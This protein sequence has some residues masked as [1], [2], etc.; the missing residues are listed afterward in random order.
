MQTNNK[1]GLLFIISGPSGCGKGTV[2]NELLARNKELKLSISATTRDMR[3]GEQEGVTY[4]YITKEEFEKLIAE[5]QLFEYNCGYSGKYYGTP[6]KYVF[7]NLDAGKDVILEIEMN[8]AAKV[9]E[10]Y[11]DGIL[12][13]LAPPSLEELHSRLVGRGR[14]SA[15]LIAERFN[16]AKAELQRVDSYDYAVV[17]DNL[18][19]AVEDIEAII[20][21]EK[22]KVKIMS[23]KV[24][25]LVK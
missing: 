24:K 3:A 13:F 1:K 11:P 7:D 6:K 8:G 14:E 25:D 5:N 15:E 22:L 10:Q 23:Q 17:N 2:C 4:F 18:L 16:E 19:E 21:A 20:R 9:K 12:I